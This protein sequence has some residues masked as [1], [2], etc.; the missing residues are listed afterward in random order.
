MVASANERKVSVIDIE[1]RLVS[2]PET[3]HALGIS[4]RTVRW[5]IQIGKLAS[6]KPSGDP[7][8]KAG[9]RLVPASEINRL[10][11]A[12]LVPARAEAQ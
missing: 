5:Y 11:Q 4:H 2:I 12:N 8:S 3:A 9:R 6:V 7:T 10:K 1:E